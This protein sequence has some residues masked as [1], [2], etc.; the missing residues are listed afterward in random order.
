MI[1]YGKAVCTNCLR[2]VDE[3]WYYIPQLNLIV[4]AVRN[5]L[6]DYQVFPVREEDKKTYQMHITEKPEKMRGLPMLFKVEAERGRE[7]W[8]FT[9]RSGKRICPH[10]LEQENRIEYLPAWSGYYDT[11]IV[12]VVGRPSAGKTAWRHACV[13]GSNLLKCQCL[14]AERVETQPLTRETVTNMGAR[15]GLTTVLEIKGERGD[16]EARLLLIDTPGELETQSGDEQITDYEWHMSRVDRCDGIVYMIDGSKETE[17]DGEWLSNLM[18]YSKG[19]I[20]VA[21]TMTKSDK[22]R[23]RCSSSPLMVRGRPVITGGYFE[24]QKKL[25]EA[26]YYEKVKRMILDKSIIRSIHP[27]VASVISENRKDVGYFL[28]SSGTTREDGGI[29][30]NLEKAENIYDPLKYILARQGLYRYEF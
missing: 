21:V 16:K 24:R 26:G 15:D 14:G 28:I 18:T 6:G 22:L 2:P 11:Y 25:A 7:K 1:K 20:P 9:L 17:I 30:L 13:Y 3:W 12:G 10:C 29:A 23:D 8:E 19:R 27:A 5:I 4:K